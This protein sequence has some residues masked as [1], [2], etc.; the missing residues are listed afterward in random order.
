[1]IIEIDCVEAGRVPVLDAADA[2]GRWTRFNFHDKQG[3]IL[4]INLTDQSA[5]QLLELLIEVV[6]EKAGLLPEHVKRALANAKNYEAERVMTA[7]EFMYKQALRVALQ[8]MAHAPSCPCATHGFGSDACN[9]GAV[10]D[11]KTVEDAL[12]K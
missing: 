3:N 6:K 1:M 7:E 10:N 8:R 5:L 4:Q 11:R 9:C 2:L 12:N